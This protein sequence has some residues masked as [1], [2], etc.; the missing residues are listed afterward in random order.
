MSTCKVGCWY[1]MRHIISS[2]YRNLYWHCV[3]RLLPWQA[4]SADLQF[5]NFNFMTA[6]R[7]D[8]VILKYIKAMTNVNLNISDTSS[9]LCLPAVT[10][11]INYNFSLML[12]YQCVYFITVYILLL[13]AKCL[14]SV[15][16][17]LFHALYITF[18]S[19]NAWL[20][21]PEF[22]SLISPI[23][24]ARPYYIPTSHFC[25]NQGNVLLD[26][27]VDSMLL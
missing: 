5:M 20:R 19:V 10:E 14:C 9:D 17:S 15:W 27:A 4:T 21:R 16:T 8:K 25:H 3:A 24:R 11:V 12:M 13:Q 23:P 1:H 6:Y 7:T 2:T 26:W 22:I 18:Y